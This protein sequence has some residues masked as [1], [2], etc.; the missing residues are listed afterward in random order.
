[1]VS[2]DEDVS[3]VD[4]L[5]VKLVCEIQMVLDKNEAAHH[6][7]E[8]WEA[9]KKSVPNVLVPPPPPDLPLQEFL[10]PQQS[11]VIQNPLRLWGLF[12]III[13]SHL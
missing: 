8:L 9:K 4:S 6:E 7:A 12:L 3:A 1:M 11:S 5:A 2:G 13:T 10:V